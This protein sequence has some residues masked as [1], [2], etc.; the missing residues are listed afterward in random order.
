[1]SDPTVPSALP[2][3]PPPL[4]L[5]LLPQAIQDARIAR[6]NDAIKQSLKEY[7]EALER[8]ILE[9]NGMEWNGT[10]RRSRGAYCNGMEWNGMVRRGAREVHTIM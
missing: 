2:S 10:T 7:D 8:C 3:S 5:P 4:P 9:W 6:D 1:M